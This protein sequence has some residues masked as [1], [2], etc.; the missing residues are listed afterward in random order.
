LEESIEP[1]TSI[2]PE[3]HQESPKQF[4]KFKEELHK[5]DFIQKIKNDSKLGS[6]FDRYA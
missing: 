3:S 5:K 6:K 4:E 1:V 2:T